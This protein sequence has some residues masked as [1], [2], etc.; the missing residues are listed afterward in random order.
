MSAELIDWRGL[1]P[2]RWKNGAGSTRELAVEPP[3][4]TMDNFEWR[5]SVAEVS[6]DA[7]FSAFAGVDRCI[8]LLRGAGMALRSP[9]GDVMLDRIGEPF[10]FAG[11]RAVVAALVDGTCEDFN[12]MV[13]RGVHQ[14][15]V[16]SLESAA[17]LTAAPVGLVA[18]L[19]GRWHCEGMVLGPGQA[20]L[21]RGGMPDLR[22]EPEA[23][24]AQAIA[25]QIRR[26]PGAS[27]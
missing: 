7:P 17:T 16:T 6:Q 23:A 9:Q 1:A 8:T 27:P 2:Q 12:V 25:V 4:A 22:I 15:Q 13:R 26:S 20:W 24:P 14:A 11:E 3:G 10:H 5:I 21:W 18:C 19:E